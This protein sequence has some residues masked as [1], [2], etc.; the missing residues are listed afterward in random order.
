MKAE[1]VPSYAS[2]MLFGAD[3]AH[4]DTNKTEQLDRFGSCLRRCFPSGGPRSTFGLG[5][6]L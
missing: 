5:L 3:Q 2:Q 1:A 4:Q 6:P